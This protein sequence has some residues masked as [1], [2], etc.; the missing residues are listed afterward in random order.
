MKSLERI[1]F[2]II[3]MGC[4]LL[5]FW[6]FLYI[7]GKKNANLFM[8]LDDTDYPVKELYFVG[9]ALCELLKLNFQ[10]EE[11]TAT[12]KMLSVLY[13]ND[14][15]D[16]YIRAIYSQRV[17]M[18]LT[19]GCFAMPAYCFS[20]GSILIYLAIMAFAMFAY[21][22][23]GKT[24]TDKIE[25]R[26]LDMLSDFSEVVSK[27][28]LLV[29]AGMILPDAWRKVSESGNTEI[30]MEMQQSVKA[31]Q[32][33]M[34]ETEAIFGFGQRCMLP[35]IKKFATTLIQGIN[36]GNA[37]LSIML[38][39]QSKEVWGTKQQVVRRQGE[40]ANDKL[41][42]PILII[43]VGILVMVLVPIF[44]GIGG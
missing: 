41:L 13:G 24:L 32:N 3:G 1:D 10:K 20:E 18:S 26:K 22:Y 37:E 14:Y 39:Q 29:N 40:L 8:V 33:G 44:A 4:I 12:R 23:Y 5:T 25:K 19:I 2:I 36:K 34:P 21:Y 9:F 30:Y 7:R 27:L 28:A 42:I 17:T 31:V 38:K 15:V 16:Y 43:F 11:D 6:F 35:E